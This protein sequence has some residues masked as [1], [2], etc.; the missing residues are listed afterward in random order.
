[1]QAI[2]LLQCNHSCGAITVSYLNVLMNLQFDKLFFGFLIKFYFTAIF[3]MIL[4]T[5]MSALLVE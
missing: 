5:V 3:H 2:S 4:F 1:M